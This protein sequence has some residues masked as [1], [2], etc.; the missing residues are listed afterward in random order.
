MLSNVVIPGS[1]TE[2]GDRA[3]Y[4]TA[5]TEVTVPNA[6]IGTEAFAGP[7]ITR[8]V[9]G[10]N[11]ESIGEKA[12]DG[13][14][15][16]TGVYV[17]AVR[18]PFANA[19]TF[20][21]Y[22][23][24]LYVLEESKDAYYNDVNCWYRFTG[25]PLTCP[26]EVKVELGEKIIADNGEEQ[27]QLSAA[28]APAN[29]TLQTVLWSSSN[30]SV[31]TVDNNGLVTFHIAAPTVKGAKSKEPQTVECEITATTLYPDT[32]IATVKISGTVSGIDVVVVDCD[33]AATGVTAADCNIYNMQGVLLKVNATQEDIDALAP[34]LYIIG[35]KKILVN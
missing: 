20:S 10:E 33:K 22:G 11:V 8:L 23:S 1:V 15:S 17:T 13:S 21:Y 4:G 18:P 28:I 19:N 16:L 3:F 14:N 6:N 24:P 2:I 34:G 31:A 25:Y 5:L 9:L 7:D 30:P 29:T 27:L 26:E 12:F 32:P 35:S